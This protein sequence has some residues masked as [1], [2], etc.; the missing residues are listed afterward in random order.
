M[1]V[2]WCLLA[3]DLLHSSEEKEPPIVFIE[4]LFQAR[5]A[6]ITIREPLAIKAEPIMHEFCSSPAIAQ[7]SAAHKCESRWAKSA[8]VDQSI[9]LLLQVPGDT[10]DLWTGNVVEFVS[11]VALSPELVHPFLRFCFVK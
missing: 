8:D 3:S 4:R 2:A 1:S 5:Y 7:A 11:A 10:R 9:R 6:H